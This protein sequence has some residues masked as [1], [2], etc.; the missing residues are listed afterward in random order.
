V[1]YNTTDGD[2]KRIQAAERSRG[3]PT[4]YMESWRATR[5]IRARDLQFLQSRVKTHLLREEVSRFDDA[6]HLLFKKKGVED[7]N[8][9]SLQ[10]RLLLGL[11]LLLGLGLFLSLLAAVLGGLLYQ[12]ASTWFIWPVIIAIASSSHGFQQSLMSVPNLLHY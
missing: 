6:L 4:L 10:P 1:K 7:R 2:R 11:E 5:S 8:V 12:I 3:N 9:H